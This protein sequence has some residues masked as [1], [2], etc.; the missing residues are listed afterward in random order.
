M[1]KEVKLITKAQKEEF[2]KFV[3]D[4]WQESGTNI[5]GRHLI[6]RDVQYTFSSPD[7][8][9]RICYHIDE[10]SAWMNGLT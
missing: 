8:V 7:E 5:I 9:S 1:S 4:K 2:L 3:I 10:L 6:I